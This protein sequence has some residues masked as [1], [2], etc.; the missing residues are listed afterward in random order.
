MVKPAFA[1]YGVRKVVDSTVEKDA[2]IKLKELKRLK[3][4]EYLVS[5]HCRYPGSWQ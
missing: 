1:L 2:E 5:E 3:R 4:L